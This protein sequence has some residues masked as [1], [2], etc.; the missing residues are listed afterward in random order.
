G[1]LITGL[2]L[3]ERAERRFSYR[4][5]Y[6]RRVRRI[7]PALILVLA[8]SCALAWLLYPAP[9]LER[10]GRDLAGS[11]A[12]AANF[13]FWERS[14]YFD[15]QP[16]A[17]PLLHLWSLGVEEQFYIV[18]PLLLGLLARWRR[19][20]AAGIALLGLLSFALNVRFSATDPSAAFYLPF[21][22]AWEPMLGAALALVP[23][24]A[25]RRAVNG[26]SLAGAFLVGAAFILVR[27]DGF[28]GWW[29]LLP[30]LGAALLI[31]AGPAG[32][33]NSRLLSARPAVVI[34]LISYPLY[35]WHWV[36]ICFGWSAGF[37]VL[38]WPGRAALAGLAFPLA[39]ATWRF[40]ERPVREGRRSS[41]PKLG[42]A[43]AALAVFGVAVWSANGLPG[44]PLP[45]EAR[46]T[47]I[48]SNRNALLEEA[49]RQQRESC[50]FEMGR[51]RLAPHCLS[52]GAKG[53]WLIWGD[54]HA[55]SVATGLRD[56]LGRGVAL[57][58][59]TTA[60]CAPQI[61]GDAPEPKPWIRECGRS[62]RLALALIRRLK[63]GVILAQRSNHESRDWE[64]FARRLRAAGASD[65]VLLGP[66]PRWRRSLS[67]IVNTELWPAVP[68][69]VGIDLDTEAVHSD[70]R[71]AARL[72]HAGDLRYVSMIGPLCGRSGCRATVPGEPARLMAIDYGHLSAAGSSYVARAIVAPQLRAR[73]PI[74]EAGN[75]E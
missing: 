62:D 48:S 61:P 27:E 64:D 68:P 46:R 14:G 52:T 6:A 66:L 15:A 65:V 71:L 16:Y 29:A 17:R 13:V 11:A 41:A 31:G 25:S 51:S 55:R 70:R 56:H 57:A 40:I 23:P 50:G 38:D 9:D 43:M 21:T 54:S 47:F 26:L 1:F 37:E 7:F 24:P 12:F 67:Q 58:Q 36:L 49:E 8:V 33:I 19:G 18:W 44:R 3:K 73:V 35:L 32:W 69:Y 20:P 45:Q 22:R 39:W 63:P 4:G 10:F 30:T 28:P 59:V 2:I 60:G 53:T 72:R 75:A 34:G 74:A 5:F 42:L